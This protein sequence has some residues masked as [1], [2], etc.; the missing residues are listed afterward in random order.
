MPYMKIYSAT[1]TL[2]AGLYAGVSA[3]AQ[4]IQDEELKPPFQIF[5][6]AK[7]FDIPL[8]EALDG[9]TDAQVDDISITEEVSQPAKPLLQT[10]FT[11]KVFVLDKRTDGLEKITLRPDEAVKV[12]EINITAQQCAEHL[13]GI[14]GNTGLYITVDDDA[15][16]NLFKGWLF[17]RTPSATSMNH[18][19]YKLSLEGCK[20]S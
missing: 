3:Q 20:Q 17:T 14:R 9:P 6:K 8:D 19:S 7:T 5:S 15:A 12:G 10:D 13:K 16:Q 2:M 11:A 4:D 18:P 1:L